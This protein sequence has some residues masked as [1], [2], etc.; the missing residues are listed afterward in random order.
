MLM[1]GLYESIRNEAVDTE[2]DNT[3]CHHCG[4]DC[5]TCDCVDCKCRDCCEQWLIIEKNR[6]AK[7]DGVEVKNINDRLKRDKP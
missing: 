5:E 4:C 2:V 3:M 7:R 1:R 6:W